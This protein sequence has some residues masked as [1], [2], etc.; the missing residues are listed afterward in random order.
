M[1]ID[2]RCTECGKLLF[3]AGAGAGTIE[4]KC[5]NR[6]CAIIQSIQIDLS[7]SSS[8]IKTTKLTLGR[9]TPIEVSRKPVG[10]N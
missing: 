4:I 8:T 1:M 3:R 6:K 7:A 2:V 5:W 9:Q 10:I